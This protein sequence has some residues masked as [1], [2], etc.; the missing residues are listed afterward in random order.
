MSKL[1][2]RQKLILEKTD[3]TRSYSVDEAVSLLAEL[4]QSVKFMES[5]DVAINLGVD[6]RKSDQV[7]RSSTVL[8]NGTGK[9]VRVAVFTQGANAE[10]ATAAGA[11]I[12]GMDDL[13]DEV[14]KGNMDFDVVIATPDAMRVVG[15][16]GQILGPRGLMP[17]PKVGT[18]TPD[19]ET[20]VRNAK[21][22][23]VRYRT[24]KNGIIH[25]PLG[26]V[27]FSAQN[28]KENLEA[29]IA[30]L[31]KARPSSAKGVYLKKITI[32]STMGPGLTIDQ[33]GLDI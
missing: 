21:A 32:S 30:D 13:A 20:A 18:V 26:K 22:G 27:E 7:V 16:L 5:L 33:S 31:K 4:G 10:K 6:A 25:S 14:K 23:Q 15:Q 9:T 19:V 12:V 11:D 24:D 8:P 1:S 2:K 3:S 29:L 17:N 28:I